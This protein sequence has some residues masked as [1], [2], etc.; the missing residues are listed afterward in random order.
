MC[1]SVPEDEDNNETNIP[2]YLEI[3]QTGFP[4]KKTLWLKMNRFNKYA[5][6]K[7]WK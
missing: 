7:T 6:T 5:C 2:L 3:I 1:R 4:L